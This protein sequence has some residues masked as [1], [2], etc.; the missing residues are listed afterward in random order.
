MIRPTEPISFPILM[1][2]MVYRLMLFSAMKRFT[3][4]GRHFLQ[5]FHIHG[6]HGQLSK[7][8]PPFTQIVA[9][10]PYLFHIGWIVTGNKIC[11]AD[12]IAGFNWSVA[13]TQAWG[14]GDTAGLFGVVGK[15]SLCVH[16]GFIA[17]DLNGVLFY[18]R[19]VPSVTP[20]PRTYRNEYPLERCLGFH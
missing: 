5:L 10:C 13:K 4:A 8:L 9:A 6:F 1:P 7:K 17:D 15:V 3:L 19:R 11:L 14:Y 2:S 18:A 12:I 16:C 20:S